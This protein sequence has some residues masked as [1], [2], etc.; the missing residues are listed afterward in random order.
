MNLVQFTLD[1]GSFCSR[2]VAD[3]FRPLP[4]SAD[5]R[6]S[7]AYQRQSSSTAAL[8]ATLCVALI[9][10]PCDPYHQKSA[11]TVSEVKAAMAFRP[12]YVILGNQRQQTMQC[13]QAVTPPVA[14]LLAD[15]LIAALEG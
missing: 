11:R 12:D 10:L 5:I 15:G 6:F 1:A 7:Q 3:R 8:Q 14:E 13:G 2:R 9:H 4:L